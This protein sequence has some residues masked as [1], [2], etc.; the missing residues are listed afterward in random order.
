MSQG[1]ENQ[2]FKTGIG[3]PWNTF[4]F[5]RIKYKGSSL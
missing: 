4:D 2:Y 5:H 1:M 3:K